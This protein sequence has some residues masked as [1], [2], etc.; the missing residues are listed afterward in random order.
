MSKKRWEFETGAAN[1]RRILR[2]IADFNAANGYAPTIRELCD[3]LGVSSTSSMAYH[4]RLLA[5]KGYLVRR[6]RTSR[7]MYITD[8]GRK[9]LNRMSRDRLFAEF[10]EG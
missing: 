10:V 8:A 7:G 5:E 2:A 6:E 9:Y 4:L 1:R 3:L